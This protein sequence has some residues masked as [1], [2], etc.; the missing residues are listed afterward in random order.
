MSAILSYLSLAATLAS[1][2]WTEVD[3]EFVDQV[4]IL[5]IVA[6]ESGRK[7]A[8][9]YLLD[10]GAG[11]SIRLAFPQGPFEEGRKVRLGTLGEVTFYNGRESI[12]NPWCL[13]WFGKM[14]IDG[15]IGGD[16]FRV[17]D[18]FIDYEKHKVFIS[19]EY[20]P[21]S[22]EE[23]LNWNTKGAWQ[24][25]LIDLEGWLI[26]ATVANE[27]LNFSIFDTGCSRSSR[28]ALDRQRPEKAPSQWIIGTLNNY[29][30]WSEKT[31]MSFGGAQP[32]LKVEIDLVFAPGIFDCVAPSD[33]G[34]QVLLSGRRKEA[35][36][37]R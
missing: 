37:W 28:P 31:P 4:P 7:E 33:L 21:D 34:K 11:A 8:R 35:W 12:K 22:F 14:N 19:R 32:G 29:Q 30:G 36:V 1:P 5:K 23:V 15:L 10:S 27:S 25:G 24:I 3:C 6:E 17:H 2:K 18:V 26:A 13:K 16:F 9:R 20:K